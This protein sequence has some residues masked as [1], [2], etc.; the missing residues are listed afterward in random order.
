M[1]VIAA[2]LAVESTVDL[3]AATQAGDSEKFRIPGIRTRTC[4][5][6]SLRVR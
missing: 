1:R 2:T 3:I 5:R 4:Y 6:I